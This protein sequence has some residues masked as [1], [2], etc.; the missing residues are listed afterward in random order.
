MG[1]SAANTTRLALFHSGERL[2]GAIERL[3]MDRF[4]PLSSTAFSTRSR[5]VRL[6]V[7][8]DDEGRG[9]SVEVDLKGKHLEATRIPPDTAD[10]ESVEF[11]GAYYSGELGVRY[12][13]DAVDGGLILSHPRMGQRVLQHVDSD[14]YVGR[15]GWVKFY[16]DIDGAVRGF[17]L[18][19]EAFGVGDVCFARWMQ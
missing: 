3:G 19:D 11:A 14:L 16:R 4:Y 18:E 9:S 1:F 7:R 8:T 2:M 12:T 17:F 13:L 5:T 6:T 10:A 15:P